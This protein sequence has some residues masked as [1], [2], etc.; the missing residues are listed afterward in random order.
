M[1]D[2]WIVLERLGDILG[3]LW[4]RIAFFLFM[5]IYIIGVFFYALSSF[6]SND[7]YPK[8]KAIS[9]AMR[10][11]F[12]DF[13]SQVRAGLFI[14]SF[15]EFDFTKN[16]FVVDAMVWFDYNKSELM[17][18]TIDKFSF[19][20]AEIKYKSPAKIRRYDDRV[21]AKYQ[22]KFSIKT[23][24]DFHRFPLEDHTLSLV[25]LNDSVS[26]EEMYFNDDMRAISFEIDKEAFIPNWHIT[27]MTVIPGYERIQFDQYQRERVV[28]VPKI[29]FSIDFHRS[30]MNNLAASWRGIYL[31]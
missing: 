14:N 3:A 8:V 29:V 18:S 24:V 23:D 27:S 21:L 10:R 16:N 2:M 15:P 20:N 7:P 19:E 11:E 22:V 4:L 17:L 31:R 5:F 28:C 30:G 12:R 9:L 26:A 1:S 25:L 13:S 6:R